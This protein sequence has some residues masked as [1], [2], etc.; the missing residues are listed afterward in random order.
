MISV[1]M[2]GR[3]GNQMFIYAFALHAGA[4]LKRRFMISYDLSDERNFQLPEFFACRKYHRASNVF[5][6][7]FLRK[8]KLRFPEVALD[9][10]G[11]P[12]VEFKKVRNWKLLTGFMQSSRYFE[13]SDALVRSE[14][15]I[16]PEFKAQFDKKYGALFSKSKTLVVHRRRGDYKEF[17][18]EKLGYDLVLPVSYYEKALSLVGNLDDF[19]VFFIGDD[20]SD[21][22]ERFGQRPNF[23]YESNDMIVD[24]QLIQNADIAIISNSSFAWWGAYLNSRPQK[25]IYAPKYWLGFKVKQEFPN[26]IMSVPWDWVDV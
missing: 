9:S 11:S 12:E 14:L 10:W 13:A 6:I 23:H 17:G 4:R 1:Q 19:E 7:R 2:S 8:L 24:F 25:N 18:D 22:K 16:R 26:S 15:E 20:C 5:L 21:L 3:L